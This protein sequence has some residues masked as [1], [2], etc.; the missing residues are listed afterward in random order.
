MSSASST[1]IDRSKDCIGVIYGSGD[2]S[3]QVV[4]AC[5]NKK[6]AC[7]IVFVSEFV[8]KFS[9][10]VP[11]IH[12]KIGK[13]GAAIDFFHQNNVNKII[14]AGAVKRP[15][16]KELSL[17][18]KGTAWLLKLG[19]SIFAGDDVLLKAVADL[20]RSEGFEII[21]GTD[22]IDDVFVQ[23][24]VLSEKKPTELEW[25]DIKKGFE[26]A[27]TIGSLDIGQSVVVCNGDVL[28][29]ECVEGTDE[30]IKRCVSLRKQQT[31][32]IL[33]KVSKPQQD[34]RLD[35]PTVGLNTIK[36]LHKHGF[37]GIAIESGHCIVIDKE[38][39]IKQINDFSMLFVGTDGKH[40]GN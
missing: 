25:M 31:G 26:V 28:G 40:G 7:C 39:F 22:F 35:L 14:F 38:N 16:F 4:E 27:K 12:T 5:I 32:G 36:N 11:Y 29:I 33:V 13:I 2:Y 17:D 3:K 9:S 15:N 20:L 34:Q 19:K 10:E 30:L 37:S 8:E 6:I 1:K 18:A 23:N 24:R 21:S